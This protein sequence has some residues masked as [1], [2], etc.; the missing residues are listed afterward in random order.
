M[1]YVESLYGHSGPV[2]CVD[3]MY[4]ETALTCGDDCTMRFWKIVDETQLIF[5]G[6]EYSIDNAKLLKENQ[7]ISGGQDGNISFWLKD[8]KKP[9]SV[10]V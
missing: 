9:V 8:K 7:F 5:K 1:A 3:S 10:C 2:N 4:Q 6:H